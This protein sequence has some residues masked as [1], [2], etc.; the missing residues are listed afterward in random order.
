MIL[1]ESLLTF[2][3]KTLLF[4]LPISSFTLLSK[5]FGGTSVA[6][7]AVIPTVTILIFWWLPVF[8]K[9]GFKLPYQ[10][11]PLLIFFFFG[12]ISTLLSVFHTIPTFRDIPWARNIAEVLV[13]FSMGVAFYLVTIFV[14]NSPERLRS[15]LRWI[16]IGG[17]ILM[18]YSWMQYGSWIVL[19]RFPV[20]MKRIQSFISSSGML[21]QQ[22][23]SGLTY[24]PSWLAHELNLVYIPIW[25]GLS[26]SGQSIFKKKLFKK[27]EYEK[28]LLI[29]AAGTLF[30]SFS[31][32]GWITMIILASYVFFRL[33]NTWIKGLSAKQ[34][35]RNISLIPARQLLFR[36]GVWFGLLAGLMAVIL[37]A[38][39]VLT[40]IDPRMAGLF[41]IQ[42]FRVYGFMGWAAKLSFA[43]RIIYWMAA[44]NV[45]KIFPMLG[46][47]F[48]L[49]G[50]YF[51]M[52]VPY[53]GSR[54]PEIN[55]VV[56][57]QNFIPNAKNLWVRLLSETG[58]VGFA[59]FSSWVL[60]HWRNADD[61]DR[62]SSPGLLKAMGLVGKL[63]VI[64]MIVE[65]FSLDTFGLPY[66]WIGLG[67][68]ASSWLIK[69]QKSAKT[70][71]NIE[72][73]SDNKT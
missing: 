61:L 42:R 16:T 12:I 19:G 20:W 31:R 66:F 25:L 49:P 7:F 5:L 44:Y 26:I 30:I 70:G 58:I 4:F 24:E 14:V 72:V 56:L 15:A 60:T 22:R 68:I 52:T 33:T 69:D 40:R 46:A 63:I 36:L 62:I 73:T 51:P 27:I 3:W 67:L 43:E 23:A 45:F 18:A 48:G 10:L 37:F 59:L 65:G 9:K 29:L 17:I 38:G 50:Y 64:A 1:S 6:P 55:K 11:K 21:F 57:T 54:L 41:D 32:I 34:K 39:I 47:G 2:F 35:D 13:T 28:L 53:F 71:A 8:I